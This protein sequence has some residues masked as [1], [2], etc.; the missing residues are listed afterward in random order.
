MILPDIISSKFVVQILGFYEEL[1]RVKEFKTWFGV[2]GSDFWL[3]LLNLFS[4]IPGTLKTSY[5]GTTQH[6]LE[7]VLI[8]FLSKCCWSHS[9]N[10]KILAT[11]LREIILK[12]KSM[13]HSMFRFHQLTQE[14]L[15]LLNLIYY[16]GF[17]FLQKLYFCILCPHFAVVC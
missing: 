8:S 11:C 1:C 10:Q 14:L 2:Y 16:N 7:S 4:T 15:L 12:Q 9:D 3:P 6:K 17:F 5:F 13:P